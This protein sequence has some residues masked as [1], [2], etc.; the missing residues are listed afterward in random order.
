MKVY[1]SLQGTRYFEK[2]KQ[3]KKDTDLT[4]IILYWAKNIKIL[5]Y[6]FEHYSNRK[7]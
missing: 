4:H 7:K 5:L 6:I 1:K 3:N 2:I